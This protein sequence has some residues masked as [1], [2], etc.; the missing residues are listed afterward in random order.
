MKRKGEIQYKN[1]QV[2]VMIW[3]LGRR[4]LAKR[5]FWRNCPTANHYHGGG[6]A[7]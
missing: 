3:P 1:V 7:S 2:K 4:K 6:K 5:D